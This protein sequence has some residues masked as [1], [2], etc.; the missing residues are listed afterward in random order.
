MQAEL[1]VHNECGIVYL[2]SQEIIQSQFF[3]SITG[4]C[5][6]PGSMPTNTEF[7]GNPLQ[8]MKIKIKMGASLEDLA[9]KVRKYTNVGKET[10][11]YM[12][13]VL[14]RGGRTANRFNYVR[15]LD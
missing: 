15:H 2:V 8:R 11:I 7:Q 4:T 12:W 10:S 1:D 14:S 13:R 9:A 5:D 6:L 3:D